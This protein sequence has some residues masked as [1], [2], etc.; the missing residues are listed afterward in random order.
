MIFCSSHIVGWMWICKLLCICHS[1][2]NWSFHHILETKEFL[3]FSSETLNI[4][5]S[6]PG[7]YTTDSPE[8]KKYL[9][10]LN[11]KVQIIDK[12]SD[13]LLNKR[14]EIITSWQHKVKYILANFAIEKQSNRIIYRILAAIARLIFK[15]LWSG[16]KLPRGVTEVAASSPC[17]SVNCKCLWKKTQ[18]NNM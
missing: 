15:C 9:L 4:K 11:E 1:Y 16:R 2:G 18:I 7:K 6:I 12:R 13:H 5:W 3:F 10:C 8:S 17:L 14:I